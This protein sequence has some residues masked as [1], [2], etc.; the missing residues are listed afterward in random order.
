M[1]VSL[2]E[3]ANDCEHS[4]RTALIRRRELLVGISIQEEGRIIW[5]LLFLFKIYVLGNI[6]INLFAG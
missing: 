3:D 1:N 6:P 5:D 2:I 4:I